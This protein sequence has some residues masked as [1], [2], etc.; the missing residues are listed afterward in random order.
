MKAS[1]PLGRWAG[2]AVGAHWS[3]LVTVGLI[4]EMMATG[5][6]PAA[7]PGYPA[8]V[9]WLA[10]IAVAVLFILCLLLHELAHAIVAR[11]Y[12]MDIERITLWLLGGATQ[13]TADPP[14][15]KIELRITLAGPLTSIGLGGLSYAAAAGATAL[16]APHLVIA[17][18]AWLTLV[19]LVL[20][21]FNLLPGQP[22]D[23]GRVLHALLWRHTGDRR[24][25]T[26][27]AGRAGSALGVVLVVVG[28]VEMLTS[29]LAGGLW[30][31][32]VGW[33]LVGSAGAETSRATL[34]GELAGIRVR[35]VMTEHPVT[36]PG[37]LT[38]DAFADRIAE[39]A[40]ARVF[41]VLDFDGRPSGLVSL[42][43]LIRLTADQRA[44]RTVG[45]V[46]RPMSGV[47]V[48]GP[49][50]PLVTALERGRP[51]AADDVLLVIEAGRLVGL[52]DSADINRA[53]E[54]ASLRH[55]VTTAPSG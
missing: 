10:G 34:R 47:R 25:A 38:V 19:N 1:I 53:I 15:P 27:I 5:G 4:A 44:V 54:L 35:E 21:V 52:V 49:D 45:S 2:V 48:V 9:Y 24:R 33:F 3:V 17:G 7:A 12:R 6:L 37:W 11:R 8:A 26:V 20:G 30:L 29:S 22:L 23:G 28:F 18:V 51:R 43:D 14:T 50:E 16:S 55:P 13:L 46:A 32:L 39:H 31:A 42:P 40:H 36:A 41:P